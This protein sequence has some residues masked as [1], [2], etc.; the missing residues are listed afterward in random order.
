MAASASTLI[1]DLAGRLR[2]ARNRANLSQRELA[3]QLRVTERTLQ[4]WESGRVLPRPVHRR[5][6]D[7]FFEKAAA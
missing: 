6:L 7:R 4:A 1:E 3:R 5:K 2:A